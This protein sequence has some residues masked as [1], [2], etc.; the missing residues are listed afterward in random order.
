M[1]H[2]VRRGA[3]PPLVLLHGIGDHWG[4]WVPVLDRVAGHR[5]VVALDLP[6]F[7]ASPPP[8]E[9]E[10]TVEA[11]AR[12]V[13]RW[14]AA[15]GLER[16]HLA[17]NSLGAAI[18]LELGRLGAARSVTGLS[19]VGFQRGAERAYAYASLRGMSA[20][21][22]HARPALLAF[23]RS[24]PGRTVAG[25][26]VFGRPWAVPP[27]ALEHTTASIR[28]SRGFDATLPHA[29]AWSWIAGDLDVPV[30]IAWGTC[31][32]LLLP[33]QAL[34]ARRLMPRARHRWLPGCGHI[35]MWDDPARVAEVL[36]GGSVDDAEREEQQKRQDGRYE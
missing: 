16:P 2:H 13:A 18:A 8:A 21:A 19:P 12:V 5:E 6:G 7:G 23:E 20:L 35:P 22:R 15:Q 24:P 11:L 27:E 33:V 28:L 25:L 14:L 4:S 34:R 3:G 36:L 9:G 1:V 30:T 10:W 17:G 31:D 32:R 29:I 26:Q